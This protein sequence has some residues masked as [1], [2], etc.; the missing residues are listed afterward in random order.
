MTH[1]FTSITTNYIPK[2]RILARSI[3]R[4]DPT[5]IFHLFLCD[6][7]PPGFDI[8]HEP[9]DHVHL[10]GQ[11]G[12]DNLR[13]WIF[14]HDVVEL[15][16]AVKGSAMVKLFDE[17]GA[18]KVIFFD[19][20][21]VVFGALDELHRRL[22]EAS[23]ILTPHQV[24]PESHD[25]AILDNEICSLK[26]GVYNLG[27]VAVRRSPAG[28]AFAHWW[29]D[30][31]LSYCYADIPNGL[32]TDQ[33]WCD[34]VPALFEGV[35]ILRDKHY[36]VA[37]WNLTHRDVTERDHVLFVDGKPL[38]FFHFSG[39][40]SGSQIMMLTKYARAG[41]PLFALHDWYIAEMEKEGQREL[42][43]I[44][45]AYSS[46]DDGAPIDRRHRFVYRNRNDLKSAFPDPFAV[47]NGHSFHR[48]T[49]EVLPREAPAIDPRRSEETLFAVDHAVAQMK[50]TLTWRIGNAVTAPLIAGRQLLTGLIKRR[51]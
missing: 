31:L 21:T 32:F 39:F 24:A 26:H 22:D 12:I 41:S 5:A 44:R 50:N 16:T 15:C 7:P 49:Q 51:F 48:W 30:R 27:F 25:G 23:V 29:R 8:E 3:R 35:H 45:F 46:Y 10:L 14:M 40:D 34:L 17:Y 42:G 19:P 18:D 11:L 38:V 33:R 20:D 4:H 37:T 28:L 13:Q 2:A 1:Y 6:I 36:N 9:F 43:A 47:S